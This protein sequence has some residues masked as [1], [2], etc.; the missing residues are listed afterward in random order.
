MRKDHVAKVVSGFDAMIMRDLIKDQ[1]LYGVAFIA[2]SADGT[3]SRLDPLEVIPV[4]EMV[5]G[6]EE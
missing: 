4:R 1:I 5:K 2:C 6:R 3:V